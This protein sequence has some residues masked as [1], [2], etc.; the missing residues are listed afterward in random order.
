VVAAEIIM[1]HTSAADRHPSCV[2]CFFQDG[3]SGAGERPFGDER[4]TRVWL[5]VSVSS[6]ILTWASLDMVDG[7]VDVR[8]WAVVGVVNDPCGRERTTDS[9]GAVGTV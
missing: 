1:S 3:A 9:V 8:E 2:R 7:V 5:S 6:S 4:M